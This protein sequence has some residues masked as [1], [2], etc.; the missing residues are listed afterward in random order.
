MG[1]IFSC[2]IAKLI[3]DLETTLWIELAGLTVG[4][5]LVFAVSLKIF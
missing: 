2:K 5:A 3:N 4:M 1:C